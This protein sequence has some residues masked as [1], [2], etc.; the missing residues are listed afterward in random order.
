MEAA[1]MLEERGWKIQVVSMPCMAVF[2]AQTRAYRMQ[3]LPP[4][5]GTRCDRS[6][7]YDGLGIHTRHTWVDAWCR[8]IWGVRTCQRGV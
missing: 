3:V 1:A 4:A 7:H 6:G 8:A 2:L 5:T